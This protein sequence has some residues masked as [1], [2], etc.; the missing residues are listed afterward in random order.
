MRKQESRE[1]SN[2]NHEM[3]GDVT[4]GESREMGR[5]EWEER[6]EEEEEGNKTRECGAAEA[7]AGGRA[8]VVV[9]ARD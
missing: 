3:E 5:L 4:L 6:R 8:V 1:E 2:E 9:A 7:E